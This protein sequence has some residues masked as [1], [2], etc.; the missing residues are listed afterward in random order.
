MM[1]SGLCWTNIFGDLFRLLALALRSKTSLAA[2]N[3]LLRKQLG[4]YQKHKIKPRRTDNPTRLTLV[5]LSVCLCEQW[6]G[7]QVERLICS[8]RIWEANSALTSRL[9]WFKT[10]TEL[11]PRQPGAATQRAS[12]QVSESAAIK[13]D[14]TAEAGHT[15]TPRRS[16]SRCASTPMPRFDAAHSPA[17]LLCGLTIGGRRLNG[18]I[19]WPSRPASAKGPESSRRGEKSAESARTGPYRGLSGALTIAG[20]RAHARI[21]RASPQNAEDRR[22][23]GGA[24]GI[25]TLRRLVNHRCRQMQA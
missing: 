17:S 19:G 16:N 25:R 14:W 5:W 6:H 2:E 3:F 7:C 8:S 20:T 22:L 24:S 1:K 15:K 18:E 21:S 10:R 4:F 23:L 13:H 12:L 11:L 9:Q